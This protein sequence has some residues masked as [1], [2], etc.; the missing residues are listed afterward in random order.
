MSVLVLNAGSSSLKLQLIDP[1]TGNSLA[2]GR[3]ERIGDGA[4]WVGYQEGPVEA[5]HMDAA[6][7]VGLDRFRAQGALHRLS[8]LTAIGHR[9]VHGGERFVQATL[10][11]D[12]VEAG[13][14]AVSH[15][16]PLHNPSNLAGIRVARRLA[17][18]V[19]S[20]AIFDTAFHHT[21]PDFAA[22]YAV[23]EAWYTQLGVRRY[24]FHGT[25]HAYVSRRADALLGLG[26]RGKIVVLHLG[27]GASACAVANGQSV[28]TTMGMTPLDGLIMGTRT[29]RLDAAVPLYVMAQTGASAQDVEDQLNRQSGLKGLCGV[30]DMREILA[31]VDAGEPTATLALDAFC[32]QA[33]CAI[34]S[35]AAAMGG[36]D[37]VVFTG[38]IG[39]N[40]PRVRRRIVAPLGYLGL[41]AGTEHPLGEGSRMD[42]G[43]VPV[44]VIPTNEE[45]EIARQTAELVGA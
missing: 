23:P 3:V 41:G 15:V 4:A 43:P 33:R 8:D 35:L 20:V 38:G 32:Y 9:V 28:D 1:T 44:L 17:P 13:I 27:N 2:K 29:G 10:I 34:G 12:T 36:L 16:A 39:E 19:P 45:L 11:T 21:M 14:E 40:N 7:Q 37:A 24:G 22:R 42:G 18:D 6:L 26:G 31:R 25:S 5:P 30:S